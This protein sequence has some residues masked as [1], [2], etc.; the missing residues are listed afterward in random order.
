[1]RIIDPSGNNPVFSIFVYDIDGFVNV[2]KEYDGER[3]I[4]VGINER[5]LLGTTCDDVI[6]LNAIVLD[7]DSKHPKDTPATAAERESAYYVAIEIL[8]WLKGHN[9]RP[10]L[11]MSGNG[12]QIWLKMDMGLDDDK[13]KLECVLKEF[14]REVASRFET[15]YCKIDNIGD[16]ARVIK[17]IGTTSVKPLATLE[18]PNLVSYWVRKPLFFEPHYTWGYKLLALAK[19]HEEIPVV[20]EDIGIIPKLT[21]TEITGVVNGLNPYA[22]QLF[23]GELNWKYKSKS[24]AE[25]AILI[26]LARSGIPKNVSYALMTYSKIGKWNN[27][28]GAYKHLTINKAY[29]LVEADSQ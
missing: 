15:P 8:E 25:F 10:F 3:N 14:Q 1:M 11:A 28:N 19:E 21:E 12:W 17:V 26:F 27:E 22:R 13:K 4:Y 18:R 24:E 2:C 5:R 23:D 29:H 16:L 6:H 20:D 7:V 9:R